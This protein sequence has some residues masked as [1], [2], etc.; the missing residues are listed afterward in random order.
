MLLLNIMYIH[1]DC[2]DY[3]VRLS[4]SGSVEFCLCNNWY[5]VTI[6]STASVSVSV[7]GAT[8][9][10]VQWTPLV[11]ERISLSA[12]HEVSCKFV[13]SDITPQV[14]GQSTLFK[15][16]APSNRSTI[17]NGAW[18]HSTYDCCVRAS[19]SNTLSLPICATNISLRTGQ[20]LVA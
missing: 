2:A 5:S 14:G 10:R 6:V 19:V 11:D 1:I 12:Y 8:S 20:L 4:Y 15:R 16:V 9:L 7:V 3:A 13:S 18:P 17:I